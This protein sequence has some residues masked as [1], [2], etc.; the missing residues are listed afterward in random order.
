MSPEAFYLGGFLIL[1]GWMI[2]NIS[3][4]QKETNQEEPPKEQPKEQMVNT[5]CML[6]GEPIS[7]R[8]PYQLSNKF[9]KCNNCNDLYNR[10]HEH[11]LTQTEINPDYSIEVTYKVIEQDHDGY[12]SDSYDETTN[13]IEETII[14]RYPNFL[15]EEDFDTDGKLINCRF[16][17]IDSV[18]H[19]NGYCG[20][21]TTYEIISA[22]K[23][24]NT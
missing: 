21:E 10:L 1:V 4:I 12:C 5:V 17:E 15:K 7:I 18:A 13:E 22:K 8:K 6:C 11:N 9:R 20:L 2:F 16:F 3:N 24:S 14:Y 23:V 19:G